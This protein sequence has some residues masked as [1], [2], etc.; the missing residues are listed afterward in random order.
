M[1]NELIVFVQHIHLIIQGL[2]KKNKID[3]LEQIKLPQVI[4]REK[5]YISNAFQ[6]FLLEQQ[7]PNYLIRISKKYHER[8]LFLSNQAY[9]NIPGVLEDPKSAE[10]QSNDLL[11]IY[12]YI[13]ISLEELIQSAIQEI[14]QLITDDLLCS[15][16]YTDEVSNKIQKGYISLKNQFLNHNL[17]SDLVILLDNYFFSFNSRHNKKFYDYEF[18]YA[19]HLLNEMIDMVEK[20]EPILWCEKISEIL[21]KYNYNSHDSMDFFKQGL[22]KLSLR[23]DNY[24]FLILQ[25]KKIKQLPQDANWYYFKSQISLKE[26]LENI[27]TVELAWLEKNNSVIRHELINALKKPILID[28]TLDEMNLWALLNIQLHKIQQTELKDVLEILQE[29]LKTIYPDEIPDY[30]PKTKLEEFQLHTVQKY[31]D[32]QIKQFK[33]LKAHFPAI[34]KENDRP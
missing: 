10:N 4:D 9:K 30:F 29:F 16:F 34:S 6:G 17:S 13:I 31:Y 20:N 23:P 28:T 22:Q 1:K 25:L 33:L 24:K 26:F 18:N 27:I 7:D 15:N 32:H 21:I 12:Q 19:K 2:N 3:K 8:L 5:R 11:A 14:N